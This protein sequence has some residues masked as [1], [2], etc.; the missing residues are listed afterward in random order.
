MADAFDDLDSIRLDSFRRDEPQPEPALVKLPRPA[1]GEAYLGGPIPVTWVRRAVGL[2][3]KAWHTASALW[4][5]G[6]RSRDKS[7]TVA[8]TAKTLRLFRLTRQAA[9]RAFT[10]LE[11]AG[12]VRVHRRTGRRLL[13]TILPVPR[14]E[15]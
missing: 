12:L 6:I 11:G 9:Y 2:P 8:L 1:K 5:V 15:R 13:V 10:T 7:A 3:G 4:F 14:K